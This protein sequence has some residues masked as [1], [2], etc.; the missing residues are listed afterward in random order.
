MKGNKWKHYL[1]ITVF[2]SVGLVFS[3]G[4]AACEAVGCLT[5]S[6]INCTTTSTTSVISCGGGCACDACESCLNAANKAMGVG[7]Y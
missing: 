1:I 4:C 5:G 2:C 6:C 7:G 3:T